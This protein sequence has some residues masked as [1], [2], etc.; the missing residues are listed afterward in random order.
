MID[1]RRTGVV[2]VLGAAA[3]VSLAGT[4]SAAPSHDAGTTHEAGARAAD[5]GTGLSPAG[6]LDLVL[7]APGDLYGTLSAALPD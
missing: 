7:A 6:P 1:L 3:A 4:A 2:A 5:G